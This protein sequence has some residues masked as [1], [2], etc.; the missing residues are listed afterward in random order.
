MLSRICLIFS[1]FSFISLLSFSSWEDSSS[2]FQYNCPRHWWQWKVKSTYMYVIPWSLA[3]FGMSMHLH[4]DKIFHITWTVWLVAGDKFIN[5]CGNVF[6]GIFFILWC[7]LYPKQSMNMWAS[8]L[9]K[10]YSVKI[11]TSRRMTRH[12][13]D[14]DCAAGGKFESWL[15]K[16]VLKN[17]EID[18]KLPR[19]ACVF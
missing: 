18:E 13:R 1:E 7:I 11:I 2:G 10:F 4:I 6:I 17:R 12:I 14:F 5:K 8:S 16:R 15:A 9:L 3:S 19:R